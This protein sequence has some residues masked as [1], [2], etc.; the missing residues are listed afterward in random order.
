M[1]SLIST[2]PSPVPNVSSSRKTS[3]SSTV[4]VT[5]DHGMN[6]D[7][8]H[9]GPGESETHVSTI[10]VLALQGDVREHAAALEAGGARAVP[11][12]RPEELA[13]LPADFLAAHKPGADGLILLPYFLGEKTP[14]HDAHARGTLV[15][16]L[17]RDLWMPDDL[18]EKV[19]SYEHLSRGDFHVTNGVSDR[20]VITQS[21]PSVIWA[22]SVR[23]TVTTPSS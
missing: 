6:S 2:R 10:G 21:A 12:R 23:P 8:N 9:G 20:I 7:G 4:I 13:G 1:S 22:T 11:V 19:A 16:L 5:S 3:S 17:T 14:I 18:R 15:G